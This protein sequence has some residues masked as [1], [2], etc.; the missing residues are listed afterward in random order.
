MKYCYVKHKKNP[1]I[2]DYERDGSLRSEKLKR[3]EL[4]ITETRKKYRKQIQTSVKSL[5]T[6]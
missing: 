5:A 1:Q 6:F 3:N 4:T 2:D